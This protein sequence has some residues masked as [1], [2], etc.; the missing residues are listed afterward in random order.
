MRLPNQQE[1]P[2]AETIQNVPNESPVQSSI[3]SL[4]ASFPA[5][6]LNTLQLAVPGKS[7]Q[8]WRTWIQCRRRQRIPDNF[9][10]LWSGKSFLIQLM[11]SHAMERGFAVADADLSPERRLAGS[12]RHG[13]C[14]VPGSCC[15]IYLRAPHLT[16]V[17]CR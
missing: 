13:T 14:Y 4:P 10:T 11:R 9:R 1:D 15:A 5:P 16:A 7:R 2:M 17:P 12:N 8:Y 3:P 6:G